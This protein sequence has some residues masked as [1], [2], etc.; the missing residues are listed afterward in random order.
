[1]A[2]SIRWRLTLW[3][4]LALAVVLVGL[5]L[6]V[7]ARVSYTL[8]RQ[9]DRKLS[10]ALERLRQDERLPSQGEARLAYWMEELKEHDNLFGAVYG[11]DGAMRA[12]TPELAADAVPP[13][14][15]PVGEARIDDRSVP[16]MGRQR[17]LVGALRLGSDEHAVVLMAPLEEVD[18]ELGHLRAALVTTVPLALAVSGAVGYWLARKA[19]GPMDRLRA[20]TEEITAERLDRRLPVANPDDEVGRLARTINEMVAR[21]ERSFNEMRRFTADASHELRTP[22]TAIRAEAEVALRGPLGPAE[23][24]HLLGS[25]LEECERLTR[26]TDQLLALAREDAGVARFE[27][28][29]ADLEAL[30]R[31]VADTMRP[32]AEAK[33]QSFEVSVEPAGAALGDEG[34]LRQVL[35]NLLDNA[36]KYTPEGGTVA[37]RLGRQGALAVLTV[38]DTGIGIPA[39][40]LPRV[41]ERFYRVDKA[42]SRQMEGTGLGLSIARSIVVAHGG[43]IE[44]ES[45][46]GRGTTVRVMLPQEMAREGR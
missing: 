44:L 11:P 19:L 5:A 31:G 28:R 40:D 26:L 41:F 46:P 18:R 6:L 34:R 2:L 20:L 24:Q 10:D 13:R 32:V 39:A 35:Y 7:Y 37:L 38:A 15:A 3:N 21:L 29:P 42:R 8:S 14:P 9:L 1:V 12:K 16:I 22:L 33:G 30:V 25:I 23:Q 17:V 27:R 4:T 45:A 36:I 43:E